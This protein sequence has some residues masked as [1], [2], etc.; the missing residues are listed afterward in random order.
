[1]KLLTVPC[2]LAI[3][4]ASSVYAQAPTTPPPYVAS[5]IR[6]NVEGRQGGTGFRPGNF[7]MTGGVDATWPSSTGG[8]GGGPASA[9]GSV[10]PFATGTAPGSATAGATP[11]NPIDI[12]TKNV[13]AVPCSTGKPLVNTPAS[14]RDAGPG[15]RAAMPSARCASTVADSLK[16]RFISSSVCYRLRVPKRGGFMP[17]PRALR[18]CWRTAC[19]DVHV[20]DVPAAVTSW[21]VTAPHNVSPISSGCS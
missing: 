20:M 12:Q 21:V 9:T 11:A 2:L 7:V 19:V 10:G 8:G 1:M 13:A 5:P 6:K 4:I 15:G 14:R 3:V 16:F 18:G 17:P